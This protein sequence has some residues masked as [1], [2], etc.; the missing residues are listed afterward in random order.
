MMFSEALGAVGRDV[1][2]GDL[3]AAADQIGGHRH[4]HV[5]HADE[6]DAFDVGHMPCSV[7]AGLVPAIH[8]FVRKQ[9][10][11]AQHKPALGPA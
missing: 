5:A 1:V 2:G 3:E 6:A 11:D 4:A 10:V 8:A 7:M 9:D